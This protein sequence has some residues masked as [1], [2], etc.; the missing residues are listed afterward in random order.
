MNKSLIDNSIV[1]DIIGMF[2]SFKGHPEDKTVDVSTI[3][4]FFNQ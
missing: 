3:Y 1:N 4:F 2:D